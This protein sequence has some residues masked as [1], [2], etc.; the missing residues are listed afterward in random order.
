MSK[1]RTDVQ[2]K[3]LA[4][5]SSFN[6]G[7][8]GNASLC[9]LKRNGGGFERLRNERAFRVMAFS[10]SICMPLEYC[11]WKQSQKEGK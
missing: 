3:R 2:T 4:I 1:S 8:M 5:S 11:L 6:K 9:E 10:K 7:M